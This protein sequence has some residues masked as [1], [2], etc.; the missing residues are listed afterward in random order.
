MNNRIYIGNLSYQS[1]E[2]TL[3]EAF[4]QF[5]EIRNVALP[6]DRETGRP[7]GFGF[8]E[9]SSSEDA[10]AAVQ[11]MNGK[12]FEGRPLRVNIAEQKQ[13][14]GGRQGGSR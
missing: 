8:I 10:Q 7:R 5:G 2:D 9:F 14:R 12:E 3:R 13:Q 4:S 11:Q 1:T 6:K